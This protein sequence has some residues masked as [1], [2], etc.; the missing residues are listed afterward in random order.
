MN[1]VRAA[2][3][4]VL[5]CLSCGATAQ[6]SGI[7]YGVAPAQDCTVGSAAPAQGKRVDASG[8]AVEGGDV[9]RISVSFD[10]AVATDTIHVA[11]NEAG[12]RALALVEIQDGDGGWRKAWEGRLAAPAP[13]FSE[14]ACF[15]PKLPQKQVVQALRLTFRDAPG[16]IDVNY[17]ALLRR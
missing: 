7:R 12:S 1:L 8:V 2:C 13:N 15:E 6:G 3:T 11:M 16:Q 10:E 4:V 14:V 5:L 17:A 9:R